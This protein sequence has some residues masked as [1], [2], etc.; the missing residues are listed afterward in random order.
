MVTII[1]RGRTLEDKHA[2]RST[3]ELGRALNKAWASCGS[4]DGAH[5]LALV[6]RR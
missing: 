1:F 4:S 2:R 6:L 5:S 3:W